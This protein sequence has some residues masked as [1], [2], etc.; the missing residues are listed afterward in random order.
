M[1]MADAGWFDGIA[2]LGDLPANEYDDYLRRIDDPSA[3]DAGDG[4]HERAITFSRKRQPFS[5]TGSQVGHIQA[6]QDRYLRIVDPRDIEPDRTLAGQRVTV[7]L[8]QALVV[9]YPGRGTHE[10]LLHFDAGDRGMK[11]ERMQFGSTVRSADAS[12][13]ALVGQVLFS[14]LLVAPDGLSIRLRTINVRSEDDAKLLAVLQSDVFRAGLDVA[15]SVGPAIG[16][17]SQTLGSI[18]TYFATRASNMPVQDG[19]LA[20]GLQRDLV[21]APKLRLGSYVLAQAPSTVGGRLWSWAD[22]VYDRERGVIVESRNR[23]AAIS[24]NYIAL[25]IGRT[26]R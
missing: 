23:D 12:T 7:Q 14:G 25:G 11:D 20:I 6:G 13:P 16:L 22:Y 9:R 19:L 5:Y 8:T 15:A 24:Y 21:D 26:E 2:L 1:G 4:Q 3:E 17:L 18:A 10:I